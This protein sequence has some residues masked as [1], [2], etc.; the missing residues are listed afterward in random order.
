MP[1]PQLRILVPLQ[2][3][4]AEGDLVRLAASLASPPWGELHLTH[5]V[6]P[7]IQP[8]PE[9]DRLLREAANLALEMGVG[10][11]PHLEEGPDVTQVIGNAIDR[12][13]CNMMVMGWKAEVQRDAILAST[14]RALAKAVNVDTLIF[15]DRNFQPARR[16]LVPTGGGAHSLLG[17]QIAH[18]LSHRWQGTLE[19]LRI[20][21]D[22]HCQPDDPILSRYC[23][24]LFDDTRLQ[25][26]LLNIDAPI[27]ILPA[28]D[29]VDP[30]VSRAQKSD[31]VV[32]GASND[33][34]QD[35][36][37]G[38]SIPDEIANRVP[39]SVLMVRSDNIDKISL[40]NIFWENT[41]RL[42]MHPVDKWDAITQMVDA[43]VEEKQIPLPE[44][45]K[46]LDAALDREKKGSTALGHQTAIPHAPIPHLPG[47][48]G[49]MGICPEGVDFQ[50]STD[51]LVRFIFLLLTPQQNYH[52]YIPILSQIATLIRPDHA[53]EA[54]LKCQTPSEVTSLLKA[55]EQN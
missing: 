6:T 45:Q 23:S 21:R 7:E 28:T 11:I 16:I 29:V 1:Y 49:C 5:V 36:Y 34:R 31:L 4:A 47:I 13:N 10:A 3:P 9:V 43:L 39:C 20:A 24:Q 18:D 15:K 55:R 41:I 17:L 35:A 46:V 51:E 27:T 50:S 42:D 44:R 2:N 19:V 48:I 40:G 14:N 38:G 22:P 30:I 33:W 25:L 26:Q 52:Y 37:L 54:I 12:W 8:P 32:L 53:R